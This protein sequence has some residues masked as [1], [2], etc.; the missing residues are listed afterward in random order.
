[1]EA[2]REGIGWGLVVA[3]AVVGLSAA[4][5]VDDST[6]LP[7]F[8]DLTDAACLGDCDLGLDEL[9]LDL[10]VLADLPD[11]ADADAAE[12]PAPFDGAED[13]DGSPD[14]DSNGSDAPDAPG[15]AVAEV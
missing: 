13:P 14:E 3:L 15:D 10:D 11:G 6:G 4:G 7:S 2:P 9:D 8:E 1:M 12:D 5:C